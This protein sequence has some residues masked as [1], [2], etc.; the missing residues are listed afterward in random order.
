MNR[1]RAFRLRAELG[2][3]QVWELATLAVPTDAVLGSTI[4]SWQ[5]DG[6]D[7][8]AESRVRAVP[9]A[10]KTPAGTRRFVGFF[11]A[12]RTS[13]L[14]AVLREHYAPVPGATLTSLCTGPARALGDRIEALGAGTDHA[15]AFSRRPRRRQPFAASSA[16]GQEAV[17]IS[18]GDAATPAGMRLMR[19]R[20]QAWL[21]CESYGPRAWVA[22]I[23]AEIGGQRI[24]REAFALLH[25][26]DEAGHPWFDGRSFGVADHPDTLPPSLRARL[27]RSGSPV[28]VEPRHGAP[29]ADLRPVFLLRVPSQAEATRARGRLPA[30]PRPAS[31]AGF[32]LDPRAPVPLEDQAG[33][34]RPFALIEEPAAALAVLA[35]VG[36]GMVYVPHADPADPRDLRLPPA[37]TWR[38]GVVPTVGGP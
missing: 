33:R 9:H 15:P 34:S 13:A 14:A 3:V 32:V 4:V 25:D 20:G 7:E 18:I 24:E 12:Q 26:D 27:E 31:G 36:A 30:P 38:L 1:V 37:G 11:T 23:R 2:D 19:V 28:R 10:L 22:P 8:E 29:L 16:D 5:A 21:L 6:P 17:G 35:R